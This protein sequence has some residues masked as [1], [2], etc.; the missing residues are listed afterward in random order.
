MEGGFVSKRP[1]VAGSGREIQSRNGSR[2]GEDYGACITS[3]HISSRSLL[4]L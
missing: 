1:A 4:T 3:T 2:Q